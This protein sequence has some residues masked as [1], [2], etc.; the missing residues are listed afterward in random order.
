MDQNYIKVAPIDVSNMSSVEKE[1]VN[2]QASA[3]KLKVV[4][5]VSYNA[6][7]AVIT[8]AKK[9][10]KVLDAERKKI[11][12]PLD[13]AKKA[14]MNLFRTPI[15]F[16]A[17]IEVDL[18][19]KSLAWLKEEQRKK[20]EEQKRR[21]AEAKKE[22]DRIRKEKEEQARK[23]K[24]KEDAAKK[25]ADRLA[26]EGKEEEARKARET[27]AK[28]AEKVEA[29]TQE[30]A[31]VFVPVAEV[32]V[33]E[34]AKGQSVK[35]LWRAEVTDPIALCKA[36]VDGILP[37]NMID[38]NMK[39]LNKLANTFKDRMSYPGLKFKSEQTLAKRI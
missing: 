35:L 20:D 27:A 7:D 21:E 8:E 30:A 37:I 4:D 11:T 17:A 18:K 33:T 36:I 34:K 16:Y 29:R 23:W 5:Q 24:E 31:E 19:T 1:A 28:A 3:N 9:R 12:K 13:E 26:S 22:E 14:V 2:L 10:F 32:E 39:E 6:A 25:E 38:P 15:D